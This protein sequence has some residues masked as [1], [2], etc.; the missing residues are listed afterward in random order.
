ML[1]AYMYLLFFLNILGLSR[2]H[3]GI[4]Q[5][6]SILH[7]APPQCN[8]TCNTITAGFTLHI[9]FCTEQKVSQFFSTITPH[10]GVMQEVTIETSN[11][12]HVPVQYKYMTAL[13]SLKLNNN[14]ISVLEDMTE[15]KDVR[16]LDLSYNRIE[17][18]PFYFISAFMNLKEL[19]LSRNHIK[20]IYFETWTIIRVMKDLDYLFLNGN[21]FEEIDAL[22]I[23][24]GKHGQDTFINLANN[25][26]S[27]GTNKYSIEV[28]SV[29]DGTV[30]TSPGLI[31]LPY[32]NLTHLTPLTRGWGFEQTTDDVP[33]N[34]LMLKTLGLLAVKKNPFT[35]DCIDC[36]ILELTQNYFHV[37]E[38]RL[39]L[40]GFVCTHSQFYNH[41]IETI[42]T[43][44]LY[45]NDDECLDG[46]TC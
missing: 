17:Q 45:C 8:V 9:S 15:M 38:Y 4:P 16:I 41:T 13:Q 30:D 6:T 21:E 29:I 23:D 12:E 40:S 1:S 39:G 22:M 28:S 11:L 18:L 43:K 3:P 19:I 33:G 7:S 46:C 10:L 36:F 14:T 31:H 35:C 20:E 37:Y 2:S 26:I 25:R 27:K 44:R 5:C 24:I 34:V 32:N 42:D